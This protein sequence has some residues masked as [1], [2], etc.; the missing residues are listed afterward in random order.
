M[1]FRSNGGASPC[2][3]IQVEF[4]AGTAIADAVQQSID[5]LKIL[6]MLAYVKF[7]FN[8][9]DVSVNANSKIGDDL[10]DRMYKAMQSKHHY[11]IV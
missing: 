1:I 5:M 7:N 2:M 4:L 10:L 8:G 3:E 9:L 6:P 11:W